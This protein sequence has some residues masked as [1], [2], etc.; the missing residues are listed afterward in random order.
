MVLECPEIVQNVF[1][2]QVSHLQKKFSIEI[3]EIHK[4]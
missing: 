2:W 4:S 1:L 3:V